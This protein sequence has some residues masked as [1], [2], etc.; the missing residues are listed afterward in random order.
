[1]SLKLEFEHRFHIASFLTVYLTDTSN[2]IQPAACMV[3]VA[4]SDP[5]SAGLASEPLSTLDPTQ[6][7]SLSGH[8]LYTL[9]WYFQVSLQKPR[10]PAKHHASLFM[11]KGISCKNFV[12]Y[13]EEDPHMPQTTGP[14]KILPCINFRLHI[15][16]LCKV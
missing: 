6:T 16:T 8:L 15:I 11:M 10:R 13:Y 7:V 5:S 1:M 3:H 12:L 2:I 9:G 14:P 4:K